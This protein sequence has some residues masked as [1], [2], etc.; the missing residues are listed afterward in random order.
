M[1]IG[2]VSLWGVG[3]LTLISLLSSCNQTEIESTKTTSLVEKVYPLLD[4]ENSR[5]FFFSSANR[6][7][8]MVNLSPDTET[9]GAWGSG[10]RHKVDT[11]RG[12]SHI[13]AWQMSGLSVMPVSTSLEKNKELFTD[14]YS[15]FS[16]ETER[17]TPGYH[18]LELDKQ[19]IA[20]EL[21]STKRVGFHKYVFPEANVEKRAVLFN[22]NAQLGPCEISDGHLTKDGNMELSGSF[23]MQPTFRR[24][25][26]LTTYFKVKLNTPI[27]S[28]ER[29]VESKNYLLHLNKSDEPV[30][31]KVA[32]SYTSV[33]NA[34]LNME[35]ELPHWQ[36]EQVVKDSQ[37]EWEGMLSRIKVEG[38]S[39]TDQRRFYTDLWHALQGRRIISDVNGAYPDNTKE[40]FRVGQLPVDV[41]GKPK[42]NHYNSDSF[43]GAQW[44]INTLWG[45]VYP[46]I[47]EEFSHSLMQYYKDGGLVP[48]GPSGGNYTYVMT[49]ASSTPFIVSAIQKNLVN[50]NLDTIF[51]ALKKNH[52][53]GGIMGKAGYEHRTDIGGGLS[54]YLKDGYVPNPLPE[55]KFGIHLDGSGQTLEYAYQDYTLAQLAKKLGKEEENKYF[56][57]RCKN[58]KNVFN[59]DEGWMGPRDVS[60]KW[61]EDFDAYDYENGFV[62]SNAAQS[63][64]FVPHDLTGLSD[65]M[66][67][68]EKAVEKL[69]E[70]FE[71][72]EELNFTSGSSHESELH[73]EYRRIPINL[74]NQP[75]IQ[76]PFVFNKLG[77]PDLTQY[78]SRT[79]VKKAFSGLAPDTGYNG[80]EDQGLMGSLNVLY[81]IGLFQMNGGTEENPEYQIGSPIFDKITIQ[82]NSKYYPGGQFV[83][84][85]NDN[86]DNHLYSDTPSFNDSILSDFTI[87]HQDIINGGE[88][89]LHMTENPN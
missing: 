1:K 60:G 28:I 53:L 29:D 66:G 2:K 33:E 22:L 27:A 78:W 9:N 87:K 49:G 68:K 50:D 56:M 41:G 39:E 31:M 16:H 82:L 14:F 85:A 61:R 36:F 48:R 63:T 47:M 10:Y 8:G 51:S 62:E 71:K 43:W 25:K 84:I 67:G 76:T 77:R 5:W 17:I 46:E 54:Y 81:K 57:A 44:T 88:L 65:L 30:L 37:A 23:V 13:H 73:P 20:V 83:I 7:F 11:V 6:P 86:S 69:N 89:I 26:P 15:S 42:F 74:G 18:Y 59:K 32:I 64:W 80:D 35:E 55:G 70:Q 3:I 45:L 24:P 19:K 75:S 4:T 40:N 21:T 72:A 58:Y 52:M 34:N 79:V 38:G 12:F